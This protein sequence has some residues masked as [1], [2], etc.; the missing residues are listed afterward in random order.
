M[1]TFMAVMSNTRGNLAVIR[2]QNVS[3]VQ[4]PSGVCKDS[5]TGLLCKWQSI[6]EHGVMYVCQE[7]NR[8]K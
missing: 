5:V 6:T 1:F 4:H 8:M 7:C 2:H 3:K